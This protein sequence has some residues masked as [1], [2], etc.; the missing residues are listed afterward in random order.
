MDKPDFW[1]ENLWLPIIVG[2]ILLLVAAT[3]NQS[4]RT[5]VWGP[6]LRSAWTA[7]RWPF[8]VRLTT[9]GRER[10][11]TADW[12]DAAQAVR[13]KH[14]AEMKAAE[15]QHAEEVRQLKQLHEAETAEARAQ[16]RSEGVVEARAEA[17]REAADAVERARVEGRAAGRAEAHM[18]ERSAT[19]RPAVS[20]QVDLVVDPA[21]RVS[22]TG[23]HTYWLEN[24]QDGVG[25]LTDVRIDTVIGEF[26]FNSGNQWPGAW[27]DGAR[28]SGELVS[29]G[30]R[31]GAR[32]KVSWTDPNGNRRKADARIEPPAR[33]PRSV[34]GF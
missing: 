28:F 34:F 25:E 16:A 31:H 21:W 29:T 10:R 19:R 26:S 15:A 32:M 7:L 11:A 24:V 5:K 17:E 3:F 1:V 18:T 20:A 6:L 27:G 12:T 33:E 14:E 30:T 23:P 22:Q 9:V 8:T 2:V 13:D 4:V